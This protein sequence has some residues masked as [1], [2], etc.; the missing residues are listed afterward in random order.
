MHISQ[1]CLF[2]SNLSEDH[3]AVSGFSGNKSRTTHRGDFNCVIRAQN[4]RLIHLVDPSAD[5]VIPD[6]HRN[7]YSVRHAQLAGHTV[8]L[9]V[10][11]G[12]LPY[13]DP[14]LFV[15]FLEDKSTGLWLLPLLPPPQAHN[16]VFSIYNAE[17]SS[18]HAQRRYYNDSDQGIMHG[19]IRIRFSKV[20]DNGLPMTPLRT[21]TSATFDQ[22]R[23]DLL[24]NHHRVGKSRLNELDRST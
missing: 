10:Q 2:T 17:P 22:D 11:A 9:G 24:N 6:S 12:L 1:Y 13:G 5:L 4:S 21:S 16:V 19:S 7:L 20:S 8:I 23:I 15:P 14:K 18:G 3:T